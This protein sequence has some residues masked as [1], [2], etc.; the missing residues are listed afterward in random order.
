MNTIDCSSI[1]LRKALWFLL[2]THK[3]E[4]NASFGLALKR[5]RSHKKLTQEDFSSTSSRTYLSTLERGLKSPT[6]EKID[7]LA[8]IL[9]VHPITMLAEAYLIKDMAADCES[10][11]ERLRSELES[12]PTR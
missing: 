12:L 5:L 8:E 7:Q 3:L 4:L 10:L 9:G 2:G 6:L 11:L 1:G